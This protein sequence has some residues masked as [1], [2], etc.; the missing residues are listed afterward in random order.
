MAAAAQRRRDADA[1]VTAAT[2][3]A[4]AMRNPTSRSGAKVVVGSKLPMA[5]DL[6]LCESR[7]E[8]RQDRGV[9]WKE[10]VFYKTGQVYTINGTAYPVGA[11]PEGV[12][13]AP[14][15]EMKAGVALTFGIPAE[16]WD[17][18]VKQNENTDM[19]RNGLVFA[20]AKRDG[21]VG[22]AR[23]TRDVQSGLGPLRPNATGKD[24]DPR[25]PKKVA[26]RLIRNTTD[27][28]DAALDGAEDFADEE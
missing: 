11:P 28:A 8:V 18:W 17:K 9:T 21:V 4:A 16:F 14:P 27:E 19:V 15:P 13:Y 22:Q 2:G 5:L 26:N 3:A 7:T 25:M 6:Q 10:E 23:E 1:P 12:E 20:A 24:K